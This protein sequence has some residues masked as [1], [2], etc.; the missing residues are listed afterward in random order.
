[1]VLSI[2]ATRQ[3]AI[4]GCADGLPFFRQRR[5]DGDRNSP[6]AHQ[7]TGPAGVDPGR[8]GFLINFLLICDYM[9]NMFDNIYTTTFFN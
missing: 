9:S 1:M 4:R 8:C 7:V 5:M 2:D 3:R 6:A